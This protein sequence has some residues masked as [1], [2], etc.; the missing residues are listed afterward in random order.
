MFNLSRTPNIIAKASESAKRLTAV[1]SPQADGPELMIMDYIGQ[2]SFG[3]GMAA[4]TVKDFLATHRADP[5]TV[6]WNSFGGDAYEGLVMHN[7]FAEHG[8][9]TSIIDGIA[10]SAA[11]IA[12]SG[13]KIIKMQA[14]SDFGIH[15]A[16]TSVYGNLNQLRGVI[17]WLE[18]VDEHQINA[19]IAKTGASRDTI[20]GWL[21]GTDDGTLFSADEALAAGFAD[22]IIPLRSRVAEQAATATAITHYRI[23]AE[24]KHKMRTRRLT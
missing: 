5:V 15:R 3:D 6:R 1:A 19:Y 7:A 9:V 23:A 11:A 20:I 16:A 10:F 14:Q 13:S 17:E 8:N 2:D 12:A 24:L 22:E 21:E 18:A 4:T